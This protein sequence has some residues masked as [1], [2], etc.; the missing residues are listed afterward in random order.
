MRWLTFINENN[1]KIE[2][3]DN[4]PRTAHA[5]GAEIPIAT[6]GARG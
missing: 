6:R 4:M 1:S 2:N 5:P 3:K